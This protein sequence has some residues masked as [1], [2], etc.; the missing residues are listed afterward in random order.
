MSLVKLHLGCGDNHLEGWQ[1]HDRDVDLTKPLPYESNSVDA[2]FT[3]HVIEHLTTHEAVNFIKE[4]YRILVLGGIL[5]TTFPSLPR[6]RETTAYSLEHFNA[7]ER[8]LRSRCSEP[9]GFKA[10]VL[11]STVFMY[12][13]KSIWDMRTMSTVKELAGFGMVRCVQIGQSLLAPEIMSGLESHHKQ[14]GEVPNFTES[15][16][17]EAMK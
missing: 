9:M 16:C 4:C 11:H 15:E 2:I 6:I 7:Y 5:R 8:F 12:G 10:L 13:H 17:V 3:E 14:I 1:N